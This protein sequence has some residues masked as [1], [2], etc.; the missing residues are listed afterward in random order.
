MIIKENQQTWLPGGLQPLTPWAR[1]LR[2]L[3]GFPKW[4]GAAA[5][6]R[7][8]HSGAGGA[9]P[10]WYGGRSAPGKPIMRMELFAFMASPYYENSYERCGS[11]FVGRR[12]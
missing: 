7:R 4:G 10:E 8:P 12:R 5:E 3:E 6:C 9:W 1:R 11:P 2:R